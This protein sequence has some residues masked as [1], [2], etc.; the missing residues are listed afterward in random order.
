MRII[1]QAGF[2]DQLIK[3]YLPL[4][5]PGE[6]PETILET[7]RVCRTLYGLFGRENVYPWI[8]LLAI[9]P[10][11][12]LEKRLIETGYL[13]AD[14]NPLSYN[15]FTI[16]KLLYNPPP[17][18]ELIGKSVLEAQSRT[19][20]P[21][22]AGRK[23]LDIIEDRLLGRGSNEEIVETQPLRVKTSK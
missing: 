1:K 21:E 15:P 8:F 11:T 4:N 10:G 12:P 17:L 18:G 7:V 9:Q 16:K 3:L 22:E 5:A 6:T 20:L 2:T 14:Y 19:T 23:T 13:D